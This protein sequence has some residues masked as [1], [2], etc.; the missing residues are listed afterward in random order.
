MSRVRAQLTRVLLASQTSQVA[1]TLVAAALAAG[2]AD[3]AARFRNLEGS[4]GLTLLAALLL[5]AVIA[6][7]SRRWWLAPVL[8]GLP[9]GLAALIVWRLEE[10]PAVWSAAAEFAVW[11]RNWLLYGWPEAPQ[12][13]WP[14]FLRLLILLPLAI[15]FQLL[16]RRLDLVPVYAGL[17]AILFIPLLIWYPASLPDLLVALGGLIILLPRQFVRIVRREKPHE[18]GLPRAPMQLLAIPAAVI[19]L[20]LAQAVVP[21]STLDWRLPALV[22]QINDWRDFWQNRPGGTRS[23]EI[24]SIAAMGF[25]PDGSRLGGPVNLDDNTILLVRADRPL[26]LKGVS[27][28]YY[29]GSSWRHETGPMYRLNSNLWWSFRQQAFN[30]NLPAGAAGR[31]FL[32]SYSQPLT[33]EIESPYPSGTL[34]AAGRVRSVTYADALDN[35]PYFAMNG[36]LFAFSSLPSFTAYTVTADY[37]ERGRAGFDESVLTLE[38]VLE[39]TKDPNWP[40]VSTAYLQ[41]PDQL[42]ASVAEAARSAV[43]PAASPYRKALDL[44]RYFQTGFSYTLTP[45]MPPAGSDFVAHFLETRQGYCVYFA[46]AMTVMARTLGIPARYAEG[47]ITQPDG[48]TGSDQTH[49]KATANSAHAWAE[50]FFANIGWVTFDPTPGN[51]IVDPDTIVR[52]EEPT[53]TPEAAEPTPESTPTPTPQPVPDKNRNSKWL[54]LLLLPLLLIL[55]ARLSLAW[56][57]RRHA[58]LFQPETVR[59]RLPD[60]AERLD[61]YYRDLLRQ[62]ACLNIQPE[63][64]ETLVVFAERADRYLRLG[65]LALPEV[66]W[67]VNRWRYGALPPTEDELGRLADY[68]RRLEDRLRESLSRFTYLLRRIL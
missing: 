37:L 18:A 21:E 68:R 59:R 20:F 31:S 1:D 62:M 57:R 29:T 48:N 36:D 25:Q 67:P 56:L 28:A 43:D 60:P 27:S 40:A 2:L 53:P 66:L 5:C 12:A 9:A 32:A 51:P 65:S 55:A 24:F 49:W 13:S 34:F 64:G 22:N 7:L 23:R 33:L 26:L 47:F 52:P 38:A 4:L 15:G 3:A 41:L 44:A 16:V 17:L 45:V 11:C 54:W 14:Y 39:R 10:W 58:I 46:T 50:L 8:A 35:P 42:P 63:P 6:L 19:C 61:F 30:A